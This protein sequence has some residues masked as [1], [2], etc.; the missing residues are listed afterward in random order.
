MKRTITGGYRTKITLQFPDGTETVD[1]VEKPKYADGAEVYAAFDV[2]PPKGRQL[3]VAQAEQTI[4]T[5]WVRI[6]YIVGI[7][8]KWRVKLGNTIFNIVSPPLDEGMKHRELYLELEA[9]E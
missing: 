2:K 1:G 3:Y 4:A 5:R 9:V 7:T 8:S 6:R